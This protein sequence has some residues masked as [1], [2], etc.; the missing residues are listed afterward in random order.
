MRSIF[1]KKRFWVGVSSAAAAV[2][3]LLDGQYI[4]AAKSVIAGLAG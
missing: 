1:K 3:Y 4:E 2:V